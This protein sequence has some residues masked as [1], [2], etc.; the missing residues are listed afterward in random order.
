[1]MT[2]TK[3]PG[4]IPYSRGWRTL[5]GFIVMQL[6]PL[7][8]RDLL[9]FRHRGTSLF[10]SFYSVYCSAQGFMSCTAQWLGSFPKDS[11]CWIV[12]RWLNRTRP[13]LG[14]GNI[15]LPPTPLAPQSSSSSCNFKRKVSHQ[16]SIAFYKHIC[17]LPFPA[18]VKF[19]IRIITHL[20]FNL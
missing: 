7:I 11:R 19:N 5:L 14:V 12:C 17:F 16:H 10:F 9:P 20:P 13:K 15:P 2:D 6:W 4:L 3:R 1:M 8:Q 18:C